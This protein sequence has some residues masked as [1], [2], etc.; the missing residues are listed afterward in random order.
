MVIVRQPGAI[1]FLFIS[2]AL[3]WFSAVPHALIVTG[4]GEYVFD[5]WGFGRKGFSLSA[6]DISLSTGILECKAI[7]TL[8]EMHEKVNGVMPFDDETVEAEIC[9]RFRRPVFSANPDFAF[10]MWT[11]SGKDRSFLSGSLPMTV[12]LFNQRLSLMASAGFRSGPADDNPFTVRIGLNKRTLDYDLGI[13][14]KGW[15]VH[16]AISDNEYASVNR[17]DY[18]PFRVDTNFFSVFYEVLN[19]VFNFINA[20]TDPIPSNRI[21]QISG[22][23]FGPI[24]PVLYVGGLYTSRDSRHDLY[25]PV[26]DTGSGG[27]VYAFF[28]YIT[29]IKEKVFSAIL[30]FVKTWQGTDAFLNELGSK[31]SFPVYSS[32][33]YRGYYL[34]PSGNLL[35][36]FQDFYYTYE[37]LGTMTFDGTIGKI[38]SRGFS[39]TVKYAWV[40][41]PY[42]AYCFF[43]N[44]SYQYHTI[45]LEVKK[46]W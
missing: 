19:P 38:I 23:F 5:D 37:G 29:P 10:G 13:G 3:S 16:A 43:C 6:G 31:A 26:A 24:L 18:R 15:E 25:L 44:D 14:F 34:D 32:G 42:I 17:S 4:S 39:V 8:S 41:R 36:G 27:L 28:P 20:E 7:R 1:R 30:T 35:A 46:H 9:Y 21:R 22:Y 12:R 33:S 2:L 45:R 11:S 40:S